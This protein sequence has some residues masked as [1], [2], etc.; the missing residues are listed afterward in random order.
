ML[1]PP[2]RRATRTVI[3]AD[4][5]DWLETADLG[6]GSIITSLPDASAFGAQGFD[7]WRPWFINA[8]TL[9]LER[10]SPYAVGIFYQTDV[11]RDGVWVDKGFLCQLGAEAAGSAL[12][13]N[14]VVC[15]VPAGEVTFGRRA[16]Y[17]HM[18]CFS[19]ALRLP[20]GTPSA[21]V[22]PGAGHMTWAQAM[23]VKACEAAVR[24]IEEHTSSQQIIDPFCG[25]GTVLAVANEHEL[26]AIG[27]D[28]SGKKCRHAR[29]LVLP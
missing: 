27:V 15:R 29:R 12:L 17:T 9:C 20:P 14:K 11:K 25:R 22:L 23:G 16:A 8:V 7:A 24:F 19:R 6:G 1:P 13:W 4:A 2:T 26:D 28:S 10:L 21:D 18:L 3:Q 5:I